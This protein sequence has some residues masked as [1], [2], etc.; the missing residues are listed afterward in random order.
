MGR[1]HEKVIGPYEPITK[2]V[3]EAE[4]KDLESDESLWAL[5]ERWCRH[6]KMQHDHEEMARRFDEFKSTV[7]H[8][9]QVNNSDLPY[10]LEI[11][12]FADGSLTE[13]LYSQAKMTKRIEAWHQKE[14]QR[15]SSAPIDTPPP[16]PDQPSAAARPRAEQRR[17]LDLA[18]DDNLGFRAQQL[19]RE[20]C[21]KMVCDVNSGAELR[22]GV[23]GVFI[24]LDGVG[25]HHWR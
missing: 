18:V 9:H 23:A 12:I 8:V 22:H 2:V 10:K 6:F 19:Q 24:L 15:D 7:H 17:L 21:T 5:Y 14:M 3:F 1:Q 25:V 11:N 20:L 13:Y 4:E 16:H